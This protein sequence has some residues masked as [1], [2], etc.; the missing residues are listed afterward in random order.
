[1]KIF[2]ACACLLLLLMPPGAKAESSC[3]LR[4]VWITNV[5]SNVLK[6]KESI[7]EAMDF[8]ADA[9]FNIV[10]PVVWNKSY[11]LYPSDVMEQRFG[12][13]I[14]PVY[15]GRDP[16]AELIV[17]AHRN[18]MEVVPWF[19]YG[20]ASSYNLGGGRML[21]KY[22]EWRALDKDGNLLKKNN[23]EWMNALD[24]QV[25]DFMTSLLVEVAEKYDVD[26]VQGD[27]RLPAMPSEGGYDAATMA[28]YRLAFGEDPPQDHQD[29]Q[30]L[31]W[32]AD[33][34]TDYLARLRWRI[35]RVDP[36]LVIS[37]SPSIYDWGLREYLQDLKTWTEA[38][39]YEIAHPQAYRY[40][41]EAYRAV[42]DS[43][44]ESQFR[45]QDLE[46]LAPGILVKVGS[47]RI[48]PELLLEC[49]AYNRASG[50][51]GEVLFFYEGLRMNDGELG[52]VLKE[53][54]YA[55][56]ARLPHRNGRIWRPK[57]IVVPVDELKVS[58]GWIETPGDGGFLQ[59]PAG[60]AGRLSADAV[61]PR[62][63][64]YD[65][66]MQLPRGEGR[67]ADARYQL[68]AG[69]DDATAVVMDQS[70][71]LAL[72]WTRIGGIQLEEGRTAGFLRLEA[73]ESD[74]MVVAGPVMLLLNRRLSPE[75]VWPEE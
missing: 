65:V 42:I 4:G 21:E 33:I 22:P 62:S 29:P 10:F 27:D 63:G 64:H 23:F 56:P 36:N 55:K 18:G 11:T 54:P 40:N 7:A 72:G 3:E 70:S 57:G 74:G 44:V 25:Q 16:L 8:L 9:G 37:V 50:I 59:L 12:A 26:G 75:V 45:A 34:L 15:G 46:K 31:Q 52:R 17:E 73:G 39:L 48:S 30:W 51:K 43:M 67:T 24:P 6:S 13:R 47:Y 19:E 53:G 68:M 66:Y 58:G 71:P 1:L 69:A 5:D 2:A 14:D 38:G 61:V 20:F 35:H 49:I 41:L 32:R 60:V 28:R